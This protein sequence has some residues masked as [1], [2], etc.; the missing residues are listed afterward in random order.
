MYHYTQFSPLKIERPTASPEEQSLYE[1]CNQMAYLQ[2]GI[3]GA[4][5]TGLLVVGGIKRGLLLTHPNAH[6]LYQVQWHFI[7]LSRVNDTLVKIPTFMQNFALQPTISIP[8]HPHGDGSECD[9]V[10]SR[11]DDVQEHDGGP[12]PL[13]VARLQLREADPDQKEVGASRVRVRGSGL[14]G[15][16]HQDK[17]LSQYVQENPDICM[18]P[19]GK[20]F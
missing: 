11:Q 6:H 20:W 8:G 7:H 1:E 10:R 13:R 17:T 5:L 2:R 4:I 18:V 3:P 9:S 16:W 12:L 19:T 14:R 15:V